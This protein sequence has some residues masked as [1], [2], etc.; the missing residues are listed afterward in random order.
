M[1]FFAVLATAC[2]QGNTDNPDASQLDKAEDMSNEAL[3]ATS[4]AAK[5][6]GEMVDDAAETVS[7]K[8]G[9]MVDAAEAEADDAK[10]NLKDKLNDL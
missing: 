6:A 7:E 8:A 10:S 4:D 5:S 2:D 9:E 1:V 3:D